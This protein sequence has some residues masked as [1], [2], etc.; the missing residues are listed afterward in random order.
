MS[1][2]VAKVQLLFYIASDLSEALSLFNNKSCAIYIGPAQN[3]ESPTHPSFGHIGGSSQRLS[4]FLIQTLEIT[5][6]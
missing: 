4:P 3:K 1:F 2:A 6:P 5:V